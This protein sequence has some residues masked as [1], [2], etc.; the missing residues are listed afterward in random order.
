MLFDL[1]V[2][3]HPLCIILQL[4]AAIYAAVS[5][6][7]VNGVE[8]EFNLIKKYT[9]FFYRLEKEYSAIR[10]KELEEQVELRVNR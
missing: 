8:I 3:L 7:Y 10:A 6:S 1:S 9:M 5:Y 2:F 4:H